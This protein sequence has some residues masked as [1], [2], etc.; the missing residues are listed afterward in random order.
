MTP[1]TQN[2]S[3]TVSQETGSERCVSMN[4]SSTLPVSED[5]EQLYR[6][7]V[8]ILKKTRRVSTNIIQRRLRIGY[9]RACMLLELMEQRGIVGAETGL[10]P[11]QI[12]VDLSTL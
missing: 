5:T 10:E 4:P 6:Q 2:N 11:R 1:T 8:G 7:A 3:E 12:L 9:N